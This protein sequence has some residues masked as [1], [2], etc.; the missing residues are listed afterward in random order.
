MPSYMYVTEEMNPNFY[1][2][3]E[4]IMEVKWHKEYVEGR[5]CDPV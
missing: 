1:G 2:V 5:N 4:K 3:L